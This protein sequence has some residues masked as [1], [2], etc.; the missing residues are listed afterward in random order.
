MDPGLADVAMLRKPLDSGAFIGQLRQEMRVELAALP[1]PW[2]EIRPRQFVRVQ[3]S[4]ARWE[5]L[6]EPRNLGWPR[7]VIVGQ[8]DA[9]PL[10]D[11]PKGAVPARWRPR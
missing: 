5:V 6:P 3:S 8:W 1:P 7:K 4:S 10:I 9:V 2:L 11:A